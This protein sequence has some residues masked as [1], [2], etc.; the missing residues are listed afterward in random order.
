MERVILKGTHSGLSLPDIFELLRFK[1]ETICC[2]IKS[3][4]LEVNFYLRSG[5]VIWA[6]SPGQIE[7]IGAY[8]VRIGAITNSLL[9]NELSQMRQ[10]ANGRVIGEVL[11]RKGIVTAEH[12]EQAFRLRTVEL[13]KDLFGKH[14]GTRRNTAGEL[15]DDMD[16]L[17]YYIDD[18]ELP[19]RFTEPMSVDNLLLEVARITDEEQSLL[20][21]IGS[22]DIPLMIQ[23]QELADDIEFSQIEWDCLKLINNRRTVNN[24]LSL[25]HH[26]RLEV[27][28][29]VAVFF[30]LGIV[31]RGEAGERKSR[32]L[33]VDDSITSRHLVSYVLS[34]AG[35]DILEAADG[36][37]A[38]DKAVADPPDLVVLDVMLP[39]RN[40][41][42]V[43][44]LLKKD[45]RTAD[46]PVI[47]LTSLTGFTDKLRGRLVR[48][49]VYLEKPFKEEELTSIARKLVERKLQRTG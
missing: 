35:F 13:A 1:R 34:E 39:G 37:S 19:R 2:S 7:P 33:V 18:D 36:E 10:R 4:E 26:S 31:K 42:E 8:L 5:R 17:V 27:L 29:A 48:A 22:V 43:C 46:V 6:D 30:N 16:I 49:D 40:G 44:S 12:V 11:I 24:L 9:M 21:L 41:Y 15:A 3:S 32:I 47:L 20:E 45:A 23:Q 38:I 14:R 25:S 28:K